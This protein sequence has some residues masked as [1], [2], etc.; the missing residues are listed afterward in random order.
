MNNGASERERAWGGHQK[1]T[2]LTTNER[3]RRGAVVPN[4]RTMQA[5]RT[6]RE[7]LGI[8]DTQMRGGGRAARDNA[9]MGRQKETGKEEHKGI[10]SLTR[11]RERGGSGHAKTGL[12]VEE[13]Q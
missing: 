1:L 11:K 13:I 5:E 9:G 10:V 4:Q 3:P 7:I 2:S 6:E 8:V 12:F